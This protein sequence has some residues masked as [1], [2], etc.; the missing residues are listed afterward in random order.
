[1]VLTHTPE[2]PVWMYSKALAPGDYQ[3]KFII[4]NV[5]RH[6][7]EQPTIYDE[8]GIINNFLTVTVES[9]GDVTCFCSNFFSSYSSTADNYS[10]H[11]ST[12][13]D[14]YNNNSPSSTSNQLKEGLMTPNTVEGLM[15][16][17]TV[18]RIR[19]NIGVAY[20]YVERDVTPQAPFRR[21][22]MHSDVSDRPFDV[23]VVNVETL[24]LSRRDDLISQYDFMSTAQTFDGTISRAPSFENVSDIANAVS[25]Y[26]GKMQTNSGIPK[27]P[28]LVSTTT[29]SSTTSSSMQ[30]HSS[31]S[32]TMT[33]SSTTVVT[34]NNERTYEQSQQHH[35]YYNN[36]IDEYDRDVAMF[37]DDDAAYAAKLNDPIG[38]L[39][40]TAP[41]RA[42]AHC[43]DPTQLAYSVRARLSSPVLGF[44]PKECHEGIKL[45]D[46]N[47][48]AV[49]IQERG[50]YKTVRSVL[51]LRQSTGRTYFE[52]F[53]FRQTTV[54]GVCIGLSTKEL[55][56]NCLCGT[57]P[58]SVGYSTSGN[59]IRTIDG[60]E[61]WSEFGDELQ[62]GCTVGCLV[63]MTW[64]SPKFS[65]SFSKRSKS[66]C[67]NSTSDQ[68]TGS[69]KCGTEIGEDD[70]GG[71]DSTEGKDCSSND[72][73]T[74]DKHKKKN[75]SKPIRLVSVEFYANGKFQ[76]RACYEF[77]GDL[78]VYPT[79]SMFAKNARVY[80]LFKG[81]DMLY[82]SC[83]PFDEDIITLDGQKV[84]RCAGNPSK[85]LGLDQTT[86]HGR[87]SLLPQR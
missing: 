23:T 7:P 30:I 11:Q 65:A 28:H 81:Q 67:S 15:T 43:S 36:R 6:A 69:E 1:M 58:N 34:I 18:Q 52:L 21:A 84:H 2:G 80:S 29:S 64:I 12:H 55:P 10:Q 73:N 79:L 59:L 56:L 40:H 24:P 32:A 3:Y 70:K 74:K 5:W 63:S 46:T 82:T 85:G 9:C 50:L 83:L 45:I 4:D 54:G 17:N 35:H 39:P 87:E 19:Q 20:R 53:I 16:P 33:D 42:S 77:V 13:V 37:I 66:D 44:N 22:Y 78:E 26:D 86:A 38:T 14:D 51:P 49:R 76:G 75:A 25:R 61:S 27:R 60:K 8:R 41:Y 68:E 57:R 31:I 71:G 72:S 62:S 48:C 47:H